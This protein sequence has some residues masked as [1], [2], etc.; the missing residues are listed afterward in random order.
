[1]KYLLVGIVLATLSF[2]AINALKCM[3]GI[4][5][6]K[7]N[8]NQDKNNNQRNEK[9]L[10]VT[11]CGAATAV[12]STALLALVKPSSFSIPNGGYKCYH[13][14]YE[15]KNSDASTIIKG[16]IYSSINVCDGKFSSSN[17][18]EV[19]CSQCDIDSCNSGGRFGFDMKLLSLTLMAL[20]AFLL[21]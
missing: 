19:F 2:Q 8:N 10:E 20:V 15:E 6:T 1:M 17:I 16:C 11:E 5:A 13:L 4:E 9:P 12:A 14:K 3:Q 21:K 7:G 18:N